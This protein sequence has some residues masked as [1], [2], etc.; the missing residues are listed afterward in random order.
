VI[1]TVSTG[2]IDI[3]PRQLSDRERE[4]LEHLLSAEF[5]GRDALRQQLDVVTVV[6]TCACGCATVDL[7]V[8]RSRAPAAELECS[9][10]VQAL[11]ERGPGV[12][13][14]LILHCADGYL[15]ELE[16]VHYDGPPLSELPIGHEIGSPGRLGRAAQS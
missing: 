5:P 8:D 14:E 16:V 4:V 11:V 15:T 12:P 13:G 1:L 6:G 10:P 9:P 2:R 7:S 3:P